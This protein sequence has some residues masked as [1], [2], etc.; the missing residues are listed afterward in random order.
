MTLRVVHPMERVERVSVPPVG[1]LFRTSVY[2]SGRDVH[3]Y[4]WEDVR[5]AIIDVQSCVERNTNV[6]L[7]SVMNN[8]ICNPRTKITMR[9]TRS[10]GYERTPRLPVELDSDS[11]LLLYVI[12]GTAFTLQGFF[13]FVSLLFFFVFRHH[14]IIGS[15]I[16][17]ARCL[18]AHNIPRELIC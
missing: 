3:P 13:L 15:E 12:F 2:S 11:S 10:L 16:K 14:E 18:N 7:A 8:A 1:L 5:R 6:C 17:T 4:A 9:E